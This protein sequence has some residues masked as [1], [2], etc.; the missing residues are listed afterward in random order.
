MRFKAVLFPAVPLR[1]HSVG[2]QYGL[3]FGERFAP[4]PWVDFFNI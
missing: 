2:A 4:L 3:Q 1:V